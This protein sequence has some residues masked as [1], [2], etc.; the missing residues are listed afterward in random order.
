MKAWNRTDRNGQMEFKWDVSLESLKH[1]WLFIH[2][3]LCKHART[4][5]SQR[6]HQLG[7]ERCVGIS[8]QNVSR[9]EKK[10]ILN[11]VH[12]RPPLQSTR[13]LT[14]SHFRDAALTNSYNQLGCRMFSRKTYQK[15]TSLSSQ[16][17][18][19]FLRLA[20]LRSRFCNS[21]MPGWRHPG[22]WNSLQ[23]S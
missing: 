15:Q 8:W 14:S 20:W 17:S 22:T 5:K 9:E 11:T 2:T 21:L 16:T 19:E 1:I 7:K 10:R 3:N 18:V 23:K 13:P 4:T 12:C 6:M